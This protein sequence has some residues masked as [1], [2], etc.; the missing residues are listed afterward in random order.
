MIKSFKDEEVLI[1]IPQAKTDRKEDEEGEPTN[2]FLLFINEH[3]SPINNIPARQPMAKGIRKAQEAIAEQFKKMAQNVFSQGVQAIDI[4]LNR[5]GFIASSSIKNVITTQDD[6]APPS[7]VTLAIRKQM[8]IK[9]TKALIVTGQMRN[10]I[11]HVIRSR[12]WLK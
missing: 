12:S 8:G 1:G 6:I 3:G 2:A 4:Y 10:A 11:T 9:S 7:D 5:A